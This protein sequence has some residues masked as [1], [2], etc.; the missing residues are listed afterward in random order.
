MDPITSVYKAYKKLPM[1]FDLFTPAQ[2]LYAI[3]H[4]KMSCINSEA[5]MESIC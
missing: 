2:I 5:E 3:T 1:Y 4:L